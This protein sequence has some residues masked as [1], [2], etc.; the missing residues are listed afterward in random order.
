MS[1]TRRTLK[2]SG[3]P[4]VCNLHDKTIILDQ[5]TGVESESKESKNNVDSVFWSMAK[6]KNF[7][8]K[9]IQ[10]EKAKSTARSWW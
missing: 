9:F 1:Y 3:F 4:K 8:L 6:G 10:T 2:R 5:P 7:G